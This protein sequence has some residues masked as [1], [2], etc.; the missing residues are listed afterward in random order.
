MEGSASA[1][2]SF[3]S[4]APLP[5]FCLFVVSCRKHG[6]IYLAYVL[7]L[8]ACLRASEAPA[9]VHRS[10]RRPGLASP[11]IRALLHD[12]SLYLVAKKPSRVL[13]VGFCG[14]VVRLC[15][16]SGHGLTPGLSVSIRPSFVP[17][18]TTEVRTQ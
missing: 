9:C 11:T 15:P 5:P 13:R 3:S 4:C 18:L 2:V 17:P 6:D 1:H 14:I 7:M 12:R 10:L 8:S 16:L